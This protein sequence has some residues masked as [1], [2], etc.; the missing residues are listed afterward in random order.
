MLLS[1]FQTTYLLD[2]WLSFFLSPEFQIK[3]DRV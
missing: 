2:F 3:F 1:E